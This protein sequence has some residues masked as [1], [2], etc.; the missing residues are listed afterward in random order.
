MDM[1]SSAYMRDHAYERACIPQ[2]VRS[3][4]HAYVCIMCVCT[5]VCVCVR[6]SRVCAFVQFVHIIYIILR[7]TDIKAASALAQ[8]NDYVS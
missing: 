1:N 6:V 7:T 3:C 4:M 5:C 8:N 2:Y